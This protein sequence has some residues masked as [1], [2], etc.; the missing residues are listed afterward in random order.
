MVRLHSQGFSDRTIATLLACNRKT[1]ARWLK[2]WRGEVARQVQEARARSESW[3]FDI[4][5]APL[6]PQRKVSFGS[7]HATLQLQ[8]KYG[9]AGWFRIRGLLKAEYGIELGATTVKQIMRLN[10]RLHLAPRRPTGVMIR[11]AR[12]GPPVSRHP[13]EHAYIDIRYLDAKP[14]GH[15]LYSPCS[16]KASR[17]RSLPAR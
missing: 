4:S 13:F 2:R 9:Y 12:E 15:Q 11:D 14:E 10:R 3:L 5:R 1:V 6:S 17:A 16:W 7:I 8:R